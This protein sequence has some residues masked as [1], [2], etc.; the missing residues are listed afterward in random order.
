MTAV[1]EYNRLRPDASLTYALDDAYIHMALAKNLAQHGVYGVTPEGFTSSSSSVLWTLLL[2]LVYAVFGVGDLAPLWLNLLSGGLALWAVWRLLG[3]LAPE[4]PGVRLAGMAALI[5]LVPLPAMILSGMEHTLQIFLT[6]LFVDLALAALQDAPGGALRWSDAPLLAVGVLLSA[7]RYESLAVI[8]LVCLILLF[9]RRWRL[10]LALGAGALLPVLAYGLVSTAQGWW[11]LP[12]PVV[13]KAYTPVQSLHDALRLLPVR[14]GRLWEFEHLRVL[15]L[16]TAAGL[17]LNWIW[18]ALPGKPAAAF[19]WLAVLFLVSA[20]AHGLFGNF[21]WFY[22]YEAYLVALGGVGLAGLL[23]TWLYRFDPRR[24]RG[25]V[26]LALALVMLFFLA[27][28]WPRGQRA[29][30]ETPYA[31]TNIYDQQI[32]MARFVKKYYAGSCVAI[33]DIG[34]ISYMGDV[35]VIDLAGLATRETAQVVLERRP[36][37]PVIAAL[38]RQ[39]QARIAIIYDNWYPGQIPAQW[40]KVGY[41]T[42]QRSVVLG[43]PTVSFYAITPD[44]IEALSKALNAY[45]PMLPQSVR[46]L[47]LR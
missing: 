35:C 4:K 29:L 46:R 6:L 45:S 28:L 11:F 42:V 38:A 30:S 20:G 14:L 15:L 32:Q 34:A 23:G 39:R 12:N 18:P 5:F 25:W 19:R 10:A 1:Q 36:L 7:V 26:F 47:V 24:L 44:E 13:V 33:N 21:H 16:V 31:M 22:R 8:G 43:G 41:W 40:T 17:I 9:R 37:G 2:A 3:R 27:P